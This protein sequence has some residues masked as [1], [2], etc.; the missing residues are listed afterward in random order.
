MSIKILGKSD[1]G[2]P[3]WPYGLNLN[4]AEKRDRPNL[5]RHRRN[6]WPKFAAD[7][8]EAQ[9]R[10]I[11]EE[12]AGRAALLNWAARHE[13]TQAPRICCPRALLR[14]SVR[15]CSRGDCMAFGGAPGYRD[16]FDHVTGWK[17][18]RQPVAV[19]ADAYREI[20]HMRERA[21]EA[22]TELGDPSVGLVVGCSWYPGALPQVVFYRTDIA[23]IDAALP[24]ADVHPNYQR[25]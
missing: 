3:L 6:P 2:G 5:S 1:E 25:K 15:S 21:G 13:V 14:P 19:A 12:E 10:L 24:L 8:P 20:P 23:A 22:H 16:V 7:D 17:R 18:G 9:Q 4:Y 11:D